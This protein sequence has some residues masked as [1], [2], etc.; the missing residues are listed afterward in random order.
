VDDTSIEKTLVLHYSVLSTCVDKFPPTSDDS[1]LIDLTT[2]ILSLPEV[3]N[4]KRFFVYAIFFSST[5]FT[6]EIVLE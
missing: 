4:F 1:V 6:D 3:T 2:S 5:N